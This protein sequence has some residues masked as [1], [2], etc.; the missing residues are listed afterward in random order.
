MKNEVG[1]PM[2]TEKVNSQYYIYPKYSDT[3]PYLF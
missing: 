3:L 2:Q 1:G